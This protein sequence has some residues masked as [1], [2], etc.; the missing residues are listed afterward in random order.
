MSKVRLH[1]FAVGLGLSLVVIFPLRYLL[2]ISSQ[3]ERSPHVKGVTADYNGDGVA[4]LV[5]INDELK[6][7]VLSSAGEDEAELSRVPLNTV[8]LVGDFNGDSYAD[9]ASFSASFAPSMSHPYNW[10]IW[11]SDSRSLREGT[12]SPPAINPLR[13]SWGLQTAKAVPADYDGDGSTDLAVFDT[14][15]G[16]WSALFML[17]EPN[18][19]KAALALP[20][21]GLRVQWGLPGDIPLTGDFDGDGKSDFT[22]VRLEESAADNPFHWLIRT[23]KADIKYDFFLGRKGDLPFA[24]DVNG[25]KQDEAIIYRAPEKGGDSGLWL[26]RFQ[27]AASVEE[28]RWCDSG[29]EPFVGDYDGDGRVDLG[30]FYAEEKPHWKILLAEGTHPGLEPAEAEK[31]R[32]LTGA[33]SKGRRLMSASFLRAHQ[34]S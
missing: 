14:R 23:Q 8:P 26:L 32:I 27:D 5:L 33:F 22:V 2:H 9:F 28:V 13:Y 30:C 11:L 34:S 29:A 31:L 19:A 12:Q 18:L 20:G 16:E 24:G 3:A 7:S 6:V 10:E 25:D 17:A 21:F 1:S 15:T 4:D